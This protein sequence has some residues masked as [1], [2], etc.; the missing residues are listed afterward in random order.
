MVAARRIPEVLGEI[1]QHRLHH[2]RIDRRRGVIVH[3][4]GELD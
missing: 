2:A 1:R 3:V 4:D